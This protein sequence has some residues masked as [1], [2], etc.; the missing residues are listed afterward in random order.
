MCLCM[1]IYFFVGSFTGA[2]V[3]SPLENNNNMLSHG[4]SES[5]S[6]SNS[7]VQY[8]ISPTQQGVSYLRTKLRIAS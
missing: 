2:G 3:M 5:G 6:D 8:S 1:Y 4:N 7:P